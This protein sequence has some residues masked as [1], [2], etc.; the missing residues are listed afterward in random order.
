MRQFG[1][2][3]GYMVCMRGSIAVRS[4]LLLLVV[5]G[6]VSALYLLDP[7]GLRGGTEP[8]PV[9]RSTIEP[10]T[11]ES[12][13][14]PARAETVERDEVEADTEDETDDAAD[15]P[16][17]DGPRFVA[18]GRVVDSAGC[19]VAG[20][21]VQHRSTGGGAPDVAKMLG[22]GGLL[23]RGG[24]ETDAE[25]RFEVALDLEEPGSFELVANHRE[26]PRATQRAMAR[27]EVTENI[28]IAL[29][30]GTSIS[31]VI[32]GAPDDVGRM[33]VLAREK[34]DSVLDSVQLF[35]L[36]AVL[37]GA[38]ALLDAKHAE[39]A[40]DRTF[41]IGG[42]DSDMTYVVW[43]VRPSGE[44]APEMAI[45]LVQ[46]GI[47]AVTNYASVR[48]GARGVELAWR[49][50]LRG[51]LHVV[52]AV[53][54][55]PVES[56]R[57]S[58]GF[59]REMKV[60]GISMPITTKTAMARRE[61]EGGRVE[62]LDLSPPEGD[63]PR[64]AVS[65]TSHGYGEWSKTVSVPTEGSFDLGTARLEPA[66]VLRVHVVDAR[67]GTGIAGANVRVVA[68]QADE[69]DGDHSISFNASTRVATRDGAPSPAS[70]DPTD[71][72]DM[73]IGGV[74]L[75]RDLEAVTDDDGWAELTVE[76]DGEI[77]IVVEHE[78]FAAAALPA[79]T[80]PR[81]GTVEREVRLLLG[82]SAD[83]TVVDT[84]GDAVP[85]AKVKRV[86]VVDADGEELKADQN[87]RATF[88][89]LTPGTHTFVLVEGAVKK[90]DG[91][92]IDLGSLAAGDGEGVEVAIV[93][94]HVAEVRLVKPARCV[95]EGTVTLDGAPLEGAKIRVGSANSK[96]ALEA[97]A[98]EMVSSMLGGMFGGIAKVEDSGSAVTDDQGRFKL[99]HVVVEPA[100]IV[101]MHASLTMPSSRSVELV[102]GINRHD[103]A[104]LST[105]VSG[106]VLGHD[107]EP[108]NGA[109]VTVFAADDDVGAELAAGLDQAEQVMSGV[110]GTT[111]TTRGVRTD[112]DGEFTLPGV[113]PER[114]LFLRVSARRHVTR[115]IEVEPVTAGTTREGVQVALAGAGRVR[116]S[117]SK[118]IPALAV[119][120]S[121]SG[122]DGGT[123]PDNVSGVLKRGRVT[124]D[125]LTPGRWK[126]E[127][128]GPGGSEPEA[129]FVDVVAGETH[130][131]DW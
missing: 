52:D 126:I 24:V 75:P 90:K 122:P 127:L 1:P 40:D 101:V 37:D 33:L 30:D 94:G 4:L 131:I 78:D 63:S 74:D 88:D 95:V 109:R 64:L 38:G 85:G 70:A 42:L 112:S 43:A 57:V 81:A 49:E 8:N 54:G 5:I 128:E 9:G 91:I 69:G 2:A 59:E 130:R 53:T 66:P 45:A 46:G 39:V 111:S 26:H 34:D 20:A 124:L 102:E 110:L 100:R 58:L 83:V 96:E 71:G 65:V 60:L 67:D 104:L 76:V 35:D 14:D 50:P 28:V 113:E 119:T 87:G 117:V 18:R 97:E 7:F 77:V 89:G 120:A 6:L 123:V 118:S 125:G 98:L 80:L 79:L 12:P 36:S 62:L 99:E 19:G 13:V 51:V 17:D 115:T 15:D 73:E 107:G 105:T 44:S 92:Q 56:M 11:D 27:S 22:L 29:R 68:P 108:L 93:D 48:G 103:F 55:E 16:V 31:G 25:G 86:G 61:F 106:R 23:E 84:N 72:V 21:R 10:T 129:Q 116:V 114:R 121:W 82:G 41:R 3:T 47:E 32:R